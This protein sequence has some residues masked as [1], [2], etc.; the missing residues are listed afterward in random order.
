MMGTSSGSLYTIAEEEHT[1]CFTPAIFISSS[2]HKRPMTLVD[3]YA[4][5]WATLSPT[6]LSAEG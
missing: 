2:R 6:V 3:K 1:K 5:G 4:S